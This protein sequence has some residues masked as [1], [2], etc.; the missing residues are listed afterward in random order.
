MKILVLGAGAIGGYYGAR[1]IQAGV[2]VTFLV[3][4]ARASALAQTG[5][6]IA[7]ELGDFAEKVKTKT[8]VQSADHF[9]AVIV[10]CKAYDLD[11]AIDAIRPA[12]KGNTVILPFLNGL[13]AYDKLDAAFAREH[14]LGGV[15]VLAVS[16]KQDGSVFHSG[17]DDTILIGA[18]DKAAEPVAQALSNLFKQSRGNRSYSD[19]VDQALWNKWVFIACGAAITS[20]M[21]GSI[22]AISKTSGGEALIKQLMDECLA[23]ASH[24]GFALNEST[25]QGL[26]SRLLD[27]RST[28]SASMARDIEQNVPRIE[29]DDIVGDMIVRAEKHHIDVPI[30]RIAYT[31]L[32]VYQLQ[33]ELIQ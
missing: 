15:A 24:E 14:V 28:W 19:N 4:P 20:L 32:Q 8:S 22:G 12:V 25:M 26:A 21:R 16:L 23:V 7:S 13:A 31:H 6:R 30:L 29:S 5:L 17:T 11:A 9:D 2:D 1:L 10:A 3:R 27:K 18:R 33:R